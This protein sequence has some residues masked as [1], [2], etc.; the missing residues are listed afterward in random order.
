VSQ[1]SIGAERLVA[2]GQGSNVPL[3][4]NDTPEGRAHNRRVEFVKQ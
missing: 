3:V 4:S 1:F 2:I